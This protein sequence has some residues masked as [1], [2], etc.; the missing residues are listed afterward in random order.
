MGFDA[1]HGARRYCQYAQMRSAH[2]PLHT[3]HERLLHI[4]LNCL[5]VN[6][7]PL[8]KQGMQK[9]HLKNW[10]GV[11]SPKNTLHFGLGAHRGLQMTL[12]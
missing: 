2:I 7:C 11:L 1:I 10:R 12:I 3:F 8:G 6:D 5:Y 4:G 9:Q